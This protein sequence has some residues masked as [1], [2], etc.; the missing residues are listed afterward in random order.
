NRGALGQRG[1]WAQSAQLFQKPR[2]PRRRPTKSFARFRD[3]TTPER[4][5][6]ATIWPAAIPRRPFRLDGPRYIFSREDSADK[7]R[8]GAVP[9]AGWHDQGGGTLARTGRTRRALGRG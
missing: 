3:R 6:A 2:A 7:P 5:Q 9:G 1:H 8:P 4:S